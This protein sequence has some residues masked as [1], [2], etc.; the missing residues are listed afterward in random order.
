MVKNSVQPRAVRHYDEF[1][2]AKRDSGTAAAVV[3]G[4]F[5]ALVVDRPRPLRSCRHILEN[6]IP[7]NYFS[8]AP[9]TEEEAGRPGLPVTRFLARN[10]G[11]GDEALY[12]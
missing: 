4:L 1:A 3:P 12:G 9:K 2:S 7:E 10:W 6:H 11:R 5:A 8:I